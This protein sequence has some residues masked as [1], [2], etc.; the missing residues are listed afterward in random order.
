MFCFVCVP[1]SLPLSSMERDR[2]NLYGRKVL[3]LSAWG[4]R[5]DAVYIV[6]SQIMQPRGLIGLGEDTLDCSYAEMKEVFEIL[7][8]DD[9][10]P[11][12]IHCTQGKDR[13]GI[14]VLLLL[15]LTGVVSEDV[16]SGDYIKSEAE[17]VAELDERMKEIRALGL[18]EDYAKCPPGFTSAIKSQLDSKYGGVGGYLLSLGIDHEKQ[19][20]IRQRLLL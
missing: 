20:K 1:R 19:E 13:T 17:L 3:S 12:L 11:V 4:Y 16:M 6:C 9:S 7:A 2:T 10:Y 18:S 8:E 15:L 14:V 5:S